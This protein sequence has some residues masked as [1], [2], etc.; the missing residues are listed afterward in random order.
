MEVGIKTA[1][2]VRECGSRYSG[3]RIVERR[4]EHL[5][6]L[7]A[8]SARQRSL[9]ENEEQRRKALL[10]RWP[11]DSRHAFGY[12][13]LIIG[14]LPVL[15]I[16]VRILASG[17][18]GGRE[19][20]FAILYTSAAIGTGLIGL[21][22]GQRY[23]PKAVKYA[24]NFSLPNRV[25][26]WILIGLAWGAISGASG[27]MVIFVIG[28]IFGAILGGL[29]GAVTV[30]IMLALHSSVNV[31]DTIEAKHFLPIAFGVTLSVCALVLGL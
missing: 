27:G 10:M 24:S 21:V 14:S 1:N 31:G 22:L 4:I 20:G 16:A 26:L 17:G 18:I 9:F 11:I 2:A 5:L 3:D 7:N 23:V 25:A 15:A 12:F 28:S 6:R 29:V 8:E 13:G 30:P 19:V